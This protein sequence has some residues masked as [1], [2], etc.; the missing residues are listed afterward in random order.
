MRPFALTISILCLVQLALVSPAG[1]QQFLSPVLYNI[2]PSNALPYQ[3]ITADFNGDGYLDLAVADWA[4]G[5]IAI[6]LGNGDGTFQQ[7]QY[8]RTVKPLSLAAGDFNGDGIL[9][10]AEVE[11]A[12]LGALNLFLGNGDGTFRQSAQINQ[13]HTPIGLAVADFNRDG[14]LDIAVANSN[15]DQAQHGFVDIFFGKGDGTFQKHAERLAAGDNPWSVAAA[16][17]NGDGF[18]DLVVGNATA[19]SPNTLVVLMNNGE[20]TFQQASTYQLGQEVVGLA[21]AD[22]NHDSKPDL[23]AAAADDEAVSVLIGNGDGT[24]A[25][26]VFYS[27]LQ[28]GTGPQSVALADFNRD[29]NL[30]IAVI[31]AYPSAALLYGNGDG[32]FQNPT[33]IAEFPDGGQSLTAADFN[34][35]GAPDLAVSSFSPAKLAVLINAQ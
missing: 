28:L 27:I 34:G 10:I 12:Q 4:K 26:P 1:G 35:D 11:G 23:V 15:Q 19:A 29:G 24:F 32:T 5:S 2:G 13:G 3:V 7:A 22:V 33:A 20:G 6:L 25:T 31:L 8:V 30:D 14:H 17:L 9:D 16:D 21:V 18:I